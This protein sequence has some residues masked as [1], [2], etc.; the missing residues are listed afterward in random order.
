MPALRA[1]ACGGPVPDGERDAACGET[2]MVPETAEAAFHS[3]RGRGGQEHLK[4]S[5]LPPRGPLALAVPDPVVGSAGWW[6]G[7]LAARGPLGASR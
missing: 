4:A 6:R 1:A 3:A 7:G 2:A 5:G